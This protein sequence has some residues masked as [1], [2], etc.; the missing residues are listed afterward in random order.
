MKTKFFATRELARIVAREEGETFV[1]MGKDAPKG[2]R[3]AV[4]F[5]ELSDVIQAVQAVEM[6]VPTQEEQTLNNEL[7][8]AFAALD[9]KQAQRPVLKAPETVRR[10]SYS[11]VKN[12]NGSTVEVFTKHS[13]KVLA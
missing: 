10:T 2:E 1:D 12:P 3:W 11:T 13:V 9:I 4:Q 7:M 8:E 5:K 6:N